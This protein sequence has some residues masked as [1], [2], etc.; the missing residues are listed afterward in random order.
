MREVELERSEVWAGWGGLG[1]PKGSLLLRWWCILRMAGSS[2]DARPGRAVASLPD[3]L[4]GGLAESDG[5]APAD[6]WHSTEWTAQAIQ[7]QYL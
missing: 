5:V 2:A 6:E 1:G 4:R 3:P 7:G